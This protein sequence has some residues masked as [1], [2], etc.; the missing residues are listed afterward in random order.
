ML[1]YT[2]GLTS[3]SECTQLREVLIDHPYPENVASLLH[4]ICSPHLKKFV[5]QFWFPH[6]QKL[7][8][9]ENANVLRQ[10]DNELRAAYDRWTKYATRTIEVAF[11]ISGLDDFALEECQRALKRLLPRLIGD[12]GVTILSRGRVFK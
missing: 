5:V 7:A 11:C 3:L 2:A 9:A 4:T 8:R 6:L 10:T 1:R 12:A